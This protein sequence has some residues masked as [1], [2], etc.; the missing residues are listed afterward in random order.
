[1]SN[2]PFDIASA[3]ADRF[4]SKR[5]AAF[6]SSITD[7]GLP[8]ETMTVAGDVRITVFQDRCDDP[9]YAQ[10]SIDKL[11]INNVLTRYLDEDDGQMLGDLIS[12]LTY[13][14]EASSLMI[15]LNAIKST[16]DSVKVNGIWIEDADKTGITLVAKHVSGCDITKDVFVVSHIAGKP[17]SEYKWELT[18][19]DGTVIDTVSNAFPPQAAKLIAAAICFTYS[20][21]ALEDAQQE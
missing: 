16:P 3:A 19:E 5:T 10:V 11:G 1:M 21:I 7:Q 14:C 4:N 20:K 15:A 9:A 18:L 12:R 17:N 2:V 8:Q 6:V 13:Q